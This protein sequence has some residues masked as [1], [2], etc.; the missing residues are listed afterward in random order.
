VCYRYRI[1]GKE[2]DLLSLAKL[3]GISTQTLNEEEKKEFEHWESKIN[4]YKKKYLENPS[5]ENVL[6]AHADELYENAADYY[7]ASQATKISDDT[8][9]QVIKIAFQCLVKT[10]EGRTVRSRMTLT[11]ITKI[12]NIHSIDEDTVAGILEIFRLQGN[13]FLKP[14]NDEQEKL[15]RNTVLDITHESLIRNWTRLKEWAKEEYED[16]QTYLD[17]NKQLQRWLANNKSSGYL[18]PIGPLTYFENWYNTCEPNANWLVRYDDR[19]IEHQQK[20]VDA[21]ENLKQAQHFIK[22]SANKLFFTR[23]VLKYGANKLLAIAAIFVLICSCTYFYFDYRKKQNENVVIEIEESSIELLKNKKI[24]PKEKADFL[25]TYER[26]HPG[27]FSK[28]L[29]ELNSDTTAFDI[30][31]EMFILCQNIDDIDGAKV[32]PFVYTLVDYLEATLDK[33]YSKRKKV[34]GDNFYIRFEN[35]IRLCFFI[36]SNQNDHKIINELINKNAIRLFQD[37]VKRKINCSIDSLAVDAVVFNSALEIILTNTNNSITNEI[38]E[39]LSPFQG[40][41]S[42][43]RFQKVFSKEKLYKADYNDKNITHNGG[44]LMLSY[45]Y[46]A[47]RNFS[48]TEMCLDSIIKYN[49]NFSSFYRNN[50][51]DIASH[52]LVNLKKE[53]VMDFEKIITKYEKYSGV[54]KIN[55][56][57][58]LIY[59]TKDI[60]QI[61]QIIYILQF[62]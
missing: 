20:F 48:K 35:F 46:G 36:K 18:L 24:K 29:G 10:D 37:Y 16:F 2:M 27:S 45:Y 41:E 53:N 56:L 5:L 7:N 60:Y 14:Y 26:L 52:I 3:G 47:K 17:F 44:Y 39:K 55:I 38:L 22:K 61:Y 54:K 59:R 32:N 19:E 28:V 1:Y 50:F 42:L 57:Q 62:R 21:E 4:T 43:L 31:L 49:P 51:Y 33:I 8:A 13:T 40:K 58:D 6:N 15:E 25:I 30:A 23:T 12:I 34:N 11:E 9:K